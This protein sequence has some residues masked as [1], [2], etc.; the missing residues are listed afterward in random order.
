[1]EFGRGRGL[2]EDVVGVLRCFAGPHPRGGP[3]APP[4][5]PWDGG[6]EALE[7]DSLSDVLADVAD[8]L[9]EVDRPQAELFA[10]RLGAVDE[11][12]A[13]L[14]DDTGR[15]LRVG[16]RQR[17]RG[18]L[19]SPSGRAIRI[20]ALADFYYSITGLHHHRRKG[21]AGRSL[22][23]HA[24]T[25]PWQAVAPG[26]EHARLEG[27][28]DLGPLHVN[29]LRVDPDA[30]RLRVEDCR[31][32]VAAGIEFASHVQD[33]GA[34]AGI[35][36]GFFLYS[37]P[38]IEPPS[39]RYDPVALL[40]EDG[41]VRSPPVFERGAVL[42][43]RN[44]RVSI[45]RV[46]QRHVRMQA[47][48]GT[49]FSPTNVVH[50]AR[51]SVGPDEPSVAIVGH[52]VIAAGRSLPV[53]LNGFVL[54][55]PPGSSLSVGDRL[56]YS[57]VEGPSGPIR[58]GIAGG[59]VLLRNGELELDMRRE[60]FWGSAPPVTFSQDETGDRNLLPRLAAGSRPDG[61]LI[62]AAIDGRNFERALGMTLHGTARLLRALGCTEATNL[63]GGSSKRMVVRGQALDLAS[64]EIIAAGRTKVSVR[65]VHTGLLL[66]PR[67]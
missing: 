56:R 7:Q 5:G 3:P 25:A 53:P 9:H 65:P 23:E 59:P 1:M 55:L 13:A 50:R 57:E 33:C 49:D 15:V 48:D 58:A 19:E 66:Y 14:A 12:I 10:R 35:S 61:R 39:Q 16:L 38:D 51:A 40:M 41:E 47:P 44:E 32:A 17:A 46:G 43:D 64:T 2:S 30:V 52:E 29:L 8:H 18:I 37:E 34:M 62:L 31:E 42:I 6:F 11:S 67:E 27:A 26:L 60:D 4:E 22:E 20:R 28:S 24:T 45:G 54:P 63:D 21:Q 36:G